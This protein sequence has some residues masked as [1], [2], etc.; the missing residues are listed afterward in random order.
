MW[1]VMDGHDL[2]A[3]YGLAFFGPFLV[4]YMASRLKA[5]WR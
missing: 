4:A 2:V 1:P 5:W 3:I